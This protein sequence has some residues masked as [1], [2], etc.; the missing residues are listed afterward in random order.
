MFGFEMVFLYFQL[1]INMAI[2]FNWLKFDLYFKNW[3]WAIFPFSNLVLTYLYFHFLDIPESQKR[4]MASKAHY[5]NFELGH[6]VL[7]YVMFFAS[8]LIL[9]VVCDILISVSKKPTAETL[10]QQ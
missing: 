4:Y 3:M 9:Q 2:L 1:T 8:S 10:G 5:G 7:Y 6:M